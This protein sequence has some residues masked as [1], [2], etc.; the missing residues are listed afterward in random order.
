LGG[1]DGRPRVRDYLVRNQHITFDEYTDAFTLSFNV[2]WPYDDSLVI[3]ELNDPETGLPGGSY[4]LNPVFEEHI[5]NM[6]NWTVDPRYRQHYPELG[7]A[8]D[9]DIS[10]F[11]NV[12]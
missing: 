7:S 12:K 8:V 3:L 1:V 6:K 4:Q 5:R 2:N 10:E 9:A 11:E